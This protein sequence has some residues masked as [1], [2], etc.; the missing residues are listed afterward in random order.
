M[1]KTVLGITG[2][3]TIGLAIV[4]INSISA[5]D[6]SLNSNAQVTFTLDNSSK[7]PL[8][9]TKP[10]NDDNTQNAVTPT[11]SVTGE[12][13][14]PSGTTGPRLT[15]DFASSFNFRSR[16]ISSVDKTYFA[17]AQNY[18]Q[19]VEGKVADTTTTGPNFV[20]VTDL[21]SGTVAGWSLKVK[22][23]GD[24]TNASDNSKLSGAKI[25]ITNGNVLNG[26]G[27]GNTISQ[28]S[29]DKI[30]ISTD[31]S[32]VMGAKSGEGYGTWLYSMGN[33]DTAGTSV[34]LTV[35]GGIAKTEGAYT[36]NLVWTLS[37]T[38]VQ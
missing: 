34:S 8:D 28:S 2:L 36:T 20:Q 38:A 7:S 21:R 6:V 26:N 29:I 24:F 37:D 23:T 14:N 31:D 5:D 12:S 15:I 11:D 1:N 22:R 19:K 27:T 17:D 3:T 35:P 33:K 32:N 4:P 30:D 18:S 13:P 16:Q 25:T 10:T 9:P